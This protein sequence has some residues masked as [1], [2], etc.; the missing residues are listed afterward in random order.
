MKMNFC[1]LC[2]HPVELK[3]TPDHSF[4]AC[5]E[6]GQT[7]FNNPKPATEIILVDELGRAAVV[8]RARNPY[9]GMLDL[10]G[11]FI[12]SG[13]TLEEGIVRE[14]REEIG[15]EPA[16]Y[17][18]PVYLA[19]A[20]ADYP[21]GQEKPEVVTAAFTAHISS[22]TPLE[23]NDDVESIE[24]VRFEDLKREDF[25]WPTQYDRIEQALEY[26]QTHTPAEIDS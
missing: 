22:Q 23:A 21:W 18:T 5:P 25:A 10:P 2:G 8:R 24:L 9:K 26:W 7:Y 1:Y 17:S 4:W 15:L 3:T 20:T 12:D 11:G 6:C 19:S 14:I 13:E 16:A